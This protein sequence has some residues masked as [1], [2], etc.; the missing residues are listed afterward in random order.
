MKIYYDAGGHPNMIIVTNVTVERQY[1]V[2][3]TSVIDV[4]KIMCTCSV[5]VAHS[6]R[7][8]VM[9]NPETFRTSSESW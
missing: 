6:F 8:K 2:D 9:R 4:V 3:V 7:I 1:S 5:L